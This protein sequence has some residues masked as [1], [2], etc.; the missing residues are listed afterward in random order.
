LIVFGGS[1]RAPVTYD[2]LWVLETVGGSFEWT[3]VTPILENGVAVHPRS[4]A[5]LTA[6]GEE[7]FLFGGQEPLTEFRFSD[8]KVLDTR[9]W[10][11][12]D[13]GVEGQAPPARHSHATG[14][15][16][17]TALLLYGG[18]GYEGALG[19]MWVYNPGTKHWAKHTLT[20]APGV[21]APPAREMHSLTMVGPTSAVVYGGRGT[22]GRVLC[23]AARMELGEMVWS[24]A[25]P[26]PFSRCAHCAGAVAPASSSQGAG[27]QGVGEPSTAAAQGRSD[28]LVYGGFTGEA[29]EGDVMRID[30][31]TLEI[32]VVRRG[33]RESDAPGTV[34]PAR[35]A[36][37]GACVPWGRN[38]NG[39]ALVAFGGVCPVEDM[40]DVAVWVASDS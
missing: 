2:D 10:T 7:V 4:G 13:A 21:E 36:H 27:A 11:W 34:P 20:A 38:G 37:A 29:V 9:T 16:A 14:C 28:V 35:F 19:D 12:R 18:S 31:T 32:E 6:I 1:D 5:S 24:A 26:T 8:L 15:L 22:D 40:S 25:E 3:R 33:P 30:G 39:Q 17:G 23:D